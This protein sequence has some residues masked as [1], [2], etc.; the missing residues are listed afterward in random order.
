[1]TNLDPAMNPTMT[2]EEAA[3]VL[4]IARAS[5]YLAAQTG[6]LPTIRVGRRILVPTA[7]LRRMLGLGESEA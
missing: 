7:S 2:V 1:M 3:G 4:G 5:A 6:D